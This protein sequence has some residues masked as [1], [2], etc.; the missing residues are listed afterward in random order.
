MKKVLIFLLFIG[1]W[2]A[3]LAQVNVG[4]IA[5]DFALKDT[6]DV[7]YNLSDYSGQVVL[8]NFFASWCAPCKIEAPFIEDSLWQAFQNLDL[9]V[10]GISVADSNW[11]IRQFVTETGITYPLLKDT[12]AN[13]FST[14]SHNAYPYNAIIDKDG[15]ISYTETGFNIAAM[16]NH[17]DSLINVT[18]IEDS[19]QETILPSTLELI[20][21]YPNPFNGQVNIRF[22]LRTP[23]PVHLSVFDINGRRIT[24]ITQN[25]SS[26][27]NDLFLDFT[28][29]ASGLYIFRLQ[30]GNDAKSG[31]F[32]LQK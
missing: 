13:L 27:F 8:I 3:A 11:Q 16:V 23:A 14:W 2:Q 15:L 30:A 9:Q 21:P 7:V 6:N 29:Q 24:D 17:V 20:G 12:D 10:I 32:I 26:G 1:F 31:Q 19:P 28:D 22:D 18:G 4:E 5:P 25:F